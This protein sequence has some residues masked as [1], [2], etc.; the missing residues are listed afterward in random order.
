[1]NRTPEFPRKQSR[2]LKISLFSDFE[3]PQENNFHLKNIQ[4]PS[5]LHPKAKSSSQKRT[6]KKNLYEIKSLQTNYNK[7][8]QMQNYLINVKDPDH[9]IV[10]ETLTQLQPVQKD[11]T[12]QKIPTSLK[13]PSHVDQVKSWI[14][15]QKAKDLKSKNPPIP[16]IPQIKPK[17]TL[18]PTS[19]IKSH[20]SALDTQ[21]NTKILTRQ[22]SNS[23]KK[24]RE[25]RKL[26][27]KS[28][29]PVL[30]KI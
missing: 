2:T 29:S 21:N 5:T 28:T 20:N 9:K 17:R 15:Q 22:I 10:T 6:I 23:I 18:T 3:D 8:T 12:T 13:E 30:N 7:Q 27:T 25:Q 14:K 26:I 4:D 11:Q 19:Q 1:M 24:A 16:S